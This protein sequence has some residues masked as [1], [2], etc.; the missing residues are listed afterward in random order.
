MP[1][2][3]QTIL[4]GTGIYQNA[5]GPMRYRLTND[6][7]FKQLLQRN[8]HVLKALICSLLHFSPDQVE[9]TSG[10]CNPWPVFDENKSVTADQISISYD[11][12]SASKEIFANWKTA[13]Q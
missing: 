3:Q 5:T 11:F 1:N 13:V 2:K 12:L 8:Q 10:G 6:Y 7:L 4:S 9:V